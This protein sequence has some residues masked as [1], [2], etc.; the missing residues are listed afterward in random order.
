MVKPDAPFT[1][2]LVT[3]WFRPQNPLH[4]L[5]AL[6]TSPVFYGMFEVVC[7]GGLTVVSGFMN[8]PFEEDVQFKREVY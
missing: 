1:A 8:P 7:F 5:D 3:A 2:G 4:E 6:A